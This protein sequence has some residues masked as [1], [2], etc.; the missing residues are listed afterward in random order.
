MVALHVAV[1]RREQ[2]QGLIEKAVSSEP[3]YQASQF[4]IDVGAG[5]H[6]SN[7]LPPG[8]LRC[9]PAV[10]GGSLQQLCFISSLGIKCVLISLGTPSDSHRQIA[11]LS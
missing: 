1:V 9:E 3:L 11:L 8:L 10:P 2:E 6:V 7:A 5:S 4:V